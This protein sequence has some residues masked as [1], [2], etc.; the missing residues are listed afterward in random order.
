MAEELI[1]G[2]EHM[3]TGAG[4]DFERATELARKMVCEWGMSPAMGPLTFGKREESIFLG[5]EFAR[6]QD[7][8][9]ATANQIDEEIRKFITTAYNGASV[10]LEQNQQTLEAIALALLEDEVLDGERIYDLLAEH[11][12]IDIEVIKRQKQK[13][14]A[15]VTESV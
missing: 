10:L 7:Y 14:E 15:E 12:D 13:T 2:P 9:E 3:T 8:S 5:K 11:S 1:F 6:H 4:N